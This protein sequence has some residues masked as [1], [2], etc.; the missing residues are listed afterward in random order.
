VPGASLDQVI[1]LV[2]ILKAG[3]VYVPLDPEAPEER[4]RYVMEDTQ[5]PLLLTHHRLQGKV[6][7]PG[8]GSE[9]GP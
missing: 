9:P 2:G 5:M 4:I 8:R 3:G 7:G 1:A 6:S